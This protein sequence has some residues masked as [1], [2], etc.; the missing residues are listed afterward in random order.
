MLGWKEYKDWEKL[1]LVL[2]QDYKKIFLKFTNTNDSIEEPRYYV[3]SNTAAPPRP[4]FP[5]A[6]GLAPKLEVYDIVNASSNVFAESF[7]VAVSG[8]DGKIYGFT[9]GAVNIIDCFG[10][11]TKKTM[12]PAFASAVANRAALDTNRNRILVTFD[13]PLSD[14]LLFNIESGTFVTVSSS[15]AYSFSPQLGIDYLKTKDKWIVGIGTELLI[16][17]AGT[18]KEE[19][20]VPN[21]ITNDSISTDKF[22]QDFYIGDE[23]TELQKKNFDLL[24]AALIGIGY[25]SADA[26]A[27]VVA[28]IAPASYQVLSHVYGG[29]PLFPV[30]K[31]AKLQGSTTSSDLLYVP[32]NDTILIFNTTTFLLLATIP[33]GAGIGSIPDMDTNIKFGSGKKRNLAIT[34]EELGVFSVIEVEVGIL[35]PVPALIQD[36]TA[37]EG[38]AI[39][40]GCDQIDG[41]TGQETI[42][43]I[44]D[45]DDPLAFPPTVNVIG[46]INGT[47]L[48]ELNTN[49]ALVYSM[50]VRFPDESSEDQINQ[51]LR[52]FTQ[53]YG[54]V[55]AGVM[56]MGEFQSVDH[57]RNVFFIPFHTGLQVGKT[58]DLFV[59]NLDG[60]QS[61]TFTI[62]YQDFDRKDFATGRFEIGKRYNVI[63]P[64]NADLGLIN[65]NR[66]KYDDVPSDENRPADQDGHGELC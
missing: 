2:A 20:I 65:S 44:A 29:A 10:S 22:S 52:Y 35:A 58:N 60:G 25:T 59:Y 53:Q 48:E 4:P 32:F 17:N 34:F 49:T 36:V 1:R 54:A 12:P 40:T 42:S 15:S 47:I 62:Y 5:P 46:D 16:L 7:T 51:A 23:F 18:L 41:I 64:Y 38:I 56:T 14:L 55:S 21:S 27:G 50:I 3:T 24:T 26:Q 43:V 33:I 8:N 28:A 57:F 30:T 13:P 11:V 45:Y 37:N 31:I 9:D 6:T 66:M 39:G 19:A 61:V 63:K